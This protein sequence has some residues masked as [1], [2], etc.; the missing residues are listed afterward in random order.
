M[1]NY[2]IKIEKLTKYFGRRLVFRDINFSIDAN[3]VVGISGPN[4]SGKST[5]MKIIAGLLLPDSGKI[6]HS[7]NQNIINENNLFNHLGFV[8][9]YLIL[10]EEFSAEENLQLFSKIRGINYDKDY[11]NELFKKLNLYDRRKDCVKTYSSGM[12]QKLKYIF[13]LIHQPE[14]LL[15]DEPTSNL[16][17]EGKNSVYFIIESIKDNK[18]I[19]IAS[20]E[21]QDLSYCKEIIFLEQYKN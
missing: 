12:K 18:I 17:S 19:I 21:H 3:G 1:N 11:A 20:N 15:L 14:I 10:Y 9:P 6:I 5:L 16:D 13:A 4:G 8:S 2:N 7:K